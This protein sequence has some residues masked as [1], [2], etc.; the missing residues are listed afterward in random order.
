MNLEI[1]NRM[2][3]QTNFNVLKDFRRVIRKSFGSDTKEVDFEKNSEKARRIIN[4]WVEKR[5][6]HKII[7]MIGP[8][9]YVSHNNNNIIVYMFIPLYH[10]TFKVWC[11]LL[12]I[13]CFNSSSAF[14]IYGFKNYSQCIQGLF[15]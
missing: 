8:G 3:L 15:P 12:C 13:T 10:Q 9:K 2:Y 4:N 7:Q 6:S 1:A 5:T 11:K 14:C